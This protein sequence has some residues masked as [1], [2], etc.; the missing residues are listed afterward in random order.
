ML[1]DEDVD[2]RLGPVTDI[3][4][5]LDLFLDVVHVQVLAVDEDAGRGFLQLVDVLGVRDGSGLGF[6]LRGGGRRSLLRRRRGLAEGVR[7]GRQEKKNQEGG[8]AVFF[9]R[10]ILIY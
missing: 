2:V 7:D 8:E 5:E 10:P 3:V 6:F 1:G 4:D 9:H